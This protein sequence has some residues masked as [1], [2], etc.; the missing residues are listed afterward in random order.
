M[1]Y[2]VDDKDLT[3]EEKLEAAQQTIRELEEI[4]R[5]KIEFQTAGQLPRA[6]VLDIWIP[7]ID[8]LNL[9]MAI[10]QARRHAIDNNDPWRRLIFQIGE[11]GR[12][13]TAKLED[14]SR[15]SQQS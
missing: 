2:V 6:Q 11:D 10:N 4:E 14:A 9:F 8:A 5:K 13:K 15:D 3:C 1:T 7:A 12:V